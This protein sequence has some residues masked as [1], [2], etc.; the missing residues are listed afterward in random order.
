M[1]IADLLT[2]IV[3]A[4]ILVAIFGVGLRRGAGAG[5]F[6]FFLILLL[7]TWAGGLWI[8]PMGPP[9]FGVSWLSYLIVGLFFAL[10]IMALLPPIEGPPPATTARAAAEMEAEAEAFV[11]LNMFFWIVL[12]GLLIA[13]VTG[14]LV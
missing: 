12:V 6:W 4:G 5:L 7:G 8:A 9:L 3:I 1:F 13:V 10:L 14:Y 11:A 2:A